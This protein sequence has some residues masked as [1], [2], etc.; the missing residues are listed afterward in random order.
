MESAERLHAKRTLTKHSPCRYAVNNGFQYQ[1]QLSRIN[2]LR[3]GDWLQTMGSFVTSAINHLRYATMKSLIYGILLASAL[4]APALSLAQSNAPVTRAQVDAELK[5]LEAAGYRPGSTTITIR[6]TSSRHR[7]VSTRST[8]RQRDTEAQCPPRV[9]PDVRPPYRPL[10]R[11][12]SS[13]TARPGA[14]CE[15]WTILM[16]VGSHASVESS[17]RLHL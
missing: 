11:G 17:A 15:A 6:L 8:A 5:Q 12:P 3:L 14:V 10:T 16:H 2:Q 9:R 1:L 7:N 13:A 4:A